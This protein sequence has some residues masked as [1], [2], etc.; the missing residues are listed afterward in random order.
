ML[1]N[2]NNTDKNQGVM[3]KRPGNYLCMLAK[4]QV[5]HTKLRKTSIKLYSED[6]ERLT[7]YTKLILGS[8]EPK[9]KIKL[10]DNV[11]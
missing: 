7:F 5:I 9:K 2:S 1:L 3:G 11:H 8:L 6:S 10:C 4:K